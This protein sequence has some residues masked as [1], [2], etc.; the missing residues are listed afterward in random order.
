M[1]GIY[2]REK[3]PINIKNLNLTDEYFK[4]KINTSYHLSSNGKNKISGSHSVLAS[5]GNL[6][7]SW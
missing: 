7:Y 2:V 6:N 1:K 3:C 4:K 5:V